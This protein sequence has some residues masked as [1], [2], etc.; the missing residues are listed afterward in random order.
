MSTAPTLFSCSTV[1]GLIIDF[2]L[3]YF[4]GTFEIAQHLLMF[5]FQTNSVDV[6]GSTTVQDKANVIFREQ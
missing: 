6:F 3:S 4:S 1:F 2:M 5:C